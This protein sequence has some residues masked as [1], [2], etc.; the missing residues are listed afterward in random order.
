M[1][2]DM[3][4]ERENR[5]KERLT[6]V[7]S[8]RSASAAFWADCMPRMFEEELVPALREFHGVLAPH[9][10]VRLAEQ[11]ATLQA[12]LHFE[13]WHLG[14]WSIGTRLVPMPSRRAWLEVR[15]GEQ[16]VERIA[17]EQGVPLDRLRLL[18]LLTDRYLMRALEGEAEQPPGTAPPGVV[19]P[20]EHPEI[21]ALSA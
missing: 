18:E 2:L 6:L 15:F 12:S 11:A 9:L 16:P 14:E 19:P 10:G 13:D 5:W 1:I 20:R 4:E 17:L 21:H 8:T 3:N 7:E